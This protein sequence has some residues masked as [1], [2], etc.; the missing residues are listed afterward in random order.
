MRGLDKAGCH[1]LCEGGGSVS[2]I[3]V[4]DV[5]SWPG[6]LVAQPRMARRRPF[7]PRL[8]QKCDPIGETGVPKQE[9][10]KP[11][12]EIRL[13]TQRIEHHKVS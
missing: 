5:Q 7:S 10:N 6:A 4:D 8:D 11:C 12:L 1:I 2:A 13:P 9:Y 3:A